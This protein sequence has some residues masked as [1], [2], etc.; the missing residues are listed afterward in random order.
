LLRIWATYTPQQIEEVN[1]V[2]PRG[3]M[4]LKDGETAAF[5]RVKDYIWVKDLLKDYCF[6]TR[7]N[8]MIDADYSTKFAPWLAHGC[9]STRYIA[10]ECRKYFLGA[11]LWRDF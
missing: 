4:E 9:V 1:A 2:D 6:D 7:H 11:L 10:K 8:G 3:V 5:Q